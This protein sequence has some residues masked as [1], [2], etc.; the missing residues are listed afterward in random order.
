MFIPNSTCLLRRK[1]PGYDKY[2]Q[3][4][5]GDKETIPF[6]LVR[7]DTKTED[8]TVRA[9]S[10]ATRGNIKEFHASGRILVPV[11][12]LPNWGD[13][14]IIHNVVFRVKEVEPRHNV[15]GVLDHYEIDF[16]KS[17]D[18]YGDGQ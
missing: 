17:E 1:L 18:K 14:L 5:Y 6:A 10:S 11:E 16:E 4:T 3:A 15:L 8:S 13:I 12:V 7:F 2:G 9:D